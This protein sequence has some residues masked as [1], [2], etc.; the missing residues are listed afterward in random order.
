[1][2]YGRPLADILDQD[3]EATFTAVGYLGL[4]VLVLEGEHYFHQIH[5]TFP[6]PARRLIS[7]HVEQADSQLTWSLLERIYGCQRQLR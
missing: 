2:V 7:D 4:I 1:M 5:T 3:W 6:C